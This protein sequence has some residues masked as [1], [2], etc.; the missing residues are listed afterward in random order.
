MKKLGMINLFFM[1]LAVS[2]QTV[3]FDENHRE[4][5]ISRPTKTL[6]L[7]VNS[8]VLLLNAESITLQDGTIINIKKP[9]GFK[10]DFKD[11]EAI[12]NSRSVVIPHGGSGTGGGG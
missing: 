2:A 7:D 6:T 1:S 11:I 5:V 4:M 9:D 3:S 12:F 8:A 10:V